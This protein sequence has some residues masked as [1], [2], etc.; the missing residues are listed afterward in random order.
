MAAQKNQENTGWMQNDLAVL[1][2]THTGHIWCQASSKTE[3]DLDESKGL[4]S[5]ICNFTFICIHYFAALALWRLYVA[6][7][8]SKEEE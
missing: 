5:L 7:L 3:F 8:V 1:L 4:S 2:S 6:I